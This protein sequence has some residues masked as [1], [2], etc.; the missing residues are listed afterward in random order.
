MKDTILVTVHEV[1][2]GPQNARRLIRPNT[3]LVGDLRPTLDEHAE[4]VRAGAVKQIEREAPAS[5]KV[6]AKVAP[7]IEQAVDEEVDG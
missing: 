1:E 4:L 7:A 2:I 3:E 5:R 6:K